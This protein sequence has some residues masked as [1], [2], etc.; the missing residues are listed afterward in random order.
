[1][2]FTYCQKI[3]LLFTRHPGLGGT[4][5]LSLPMF[6]ALRRFSILMTMLAELYILGYE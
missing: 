2:L 1:M 6:T 3:M 5:T 4:K